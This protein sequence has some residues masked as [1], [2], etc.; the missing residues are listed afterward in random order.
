MRDVGWF[1]IAARILIV[2]IVVLAVYVVYRNHQAGQTQRGVIW[3]SV[4]LIVAMGLAFAPVLADHW[5]E[6]RARQKA[7]DAAEQ[8]R[9]S[10]AFLREKEDRQVKLKQCAARIA[11]L[12]ERLVFARLR[13]DALRKELTS[14]NHQGET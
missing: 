8:A 13:L 7:E 4:L 9:Q 3:G 14:T 2:A 5:W 6:R 12:Q 1:T 11:D 10:E